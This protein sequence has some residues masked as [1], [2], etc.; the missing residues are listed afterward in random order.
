MPL[1]RVDASAERD[2][3]SGIASETTVS[4]YAH[5]PPSCYR[6][7]EEIMRYFKKTISILAILTFVV[8]FATYTQA[9]SSAGKININT[10]EVKELV[11]LKQVGPKLAQRIVQFRNENGPFK[12]T[13]DIVKVS[14]VGKTILQLN[15]DSMTVE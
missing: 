11:A 10:A 14:G 1:R 2:I 13:E 8:V 4:G 12:T 7:K 3:K 15:K 5:N 9:E 6:K